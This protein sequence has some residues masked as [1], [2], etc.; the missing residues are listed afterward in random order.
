MCCDVN[1]QLKFFFEEPINDQK[2]FAQSKVSETTDQAF[3]D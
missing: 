2:Y 3:S 1:A